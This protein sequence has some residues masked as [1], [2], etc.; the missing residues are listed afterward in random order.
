MDFYERQLCV[1][2]F[3][4]HSCVLFKDDWALILRGDKDVKMILAKTSES[5][6]LG[7]SLQFFSPMRIMKIEKIR[8]GIKEH[9]PMNSKVSAK[10]VASPNISAA[11]RR[12]VNTKR[13]KSRVK[14]LA[15]SGP[16]PHWL[17]Q[18]NGMWEVY[19]RK[20]M[21]LEQW[22]SL[23]YN[24]SFP[25]LVHYSEF[26]HYRMG[27]KAMPLQW[28]RVKLLTIEQLFSLCYIYPLTL[29]LNLVRALN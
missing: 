23:P 18:T 24:R 1:C 19:W 11:T 21:T 4:S 22:L 29:S 5:S 9:H 2:Y 13:G 10:Y 16:C 8:T 17:R 14:T 12:E 28:Q 20:S 25:F 7:I 27:G 26:L 6:K 3:H 15:K